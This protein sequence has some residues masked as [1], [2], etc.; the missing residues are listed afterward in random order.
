MPRTVSDIG[1]M[2][3]PL[4]EF[5]EHWGFEPWSRGGLVG[6]SRLQRFVKDGFLGCIAEYRAWDCLVWDAGGEEDRRELWRHVKPMPEVMTQ[7]FVFLLEDPWPERRIRSF[8]FGLRGYVEFY[9]Y[10]PLSPGGAASVAA[11][12]LTELVHMGVRLSAKGSVFE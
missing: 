7:R 8:L 6:V 12:D 4:S 10:N 3:E 1:P 2:L 9:G 11:K 5:W